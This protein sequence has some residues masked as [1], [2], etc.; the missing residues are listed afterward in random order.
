[1]S[2]IH[3]P[4]HWVF[5]ISPFKKLSV[6]IM[7]FLHGQNTNAKGKNVMFYRKKTVEHLNQ[8]CLL[9]CVLF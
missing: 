1:M 4:C 8:I 7:H 5:F 2:N 9:K 6:Y 3:T